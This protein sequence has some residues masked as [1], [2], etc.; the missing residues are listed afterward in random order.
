[1]P[2]RKLISDL[3]VFT[4]VRRLMSASGE[5]AASFSA[6][7]RATGLAGATLVQRF[8][9]QERMVQA[10][11][12]AAWDALGA[13]TTEAAAMTEISPKGALALLKSLAPK[14]PEVEDPRL[15]DAHLRD[16]ALRAR[17]AEW[18]GQVEEALALRLGGGAKG[19]TLA[20]IVFS[21]WQGQLSWQSVGGKGFRLKDLIKRLTS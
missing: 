5:K 8:G 16:P 12:V 10:A 19:Q 3:E 11:L 17:A 18:R 15:L 13:R 1:M 4:T 9:S 21:A 6:V 14:S 20:A 2:R 7:A